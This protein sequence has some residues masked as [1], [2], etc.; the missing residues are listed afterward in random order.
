MH[1][2]TVTFANNVNLAADAEMDRKMGKKAREHPK[3]KV[4]RHAKEA[5]EAIRMLG[6]EVAAKN[7][8]RGGH[9]TNS[10]GRYRHLK[11]GGKGPCRT[12]K[13]PE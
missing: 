12:A 9:S 4:T 2:N 8:D 1:T 5:L 13:P 7:T 6:S 11:D 3:Q 10:A